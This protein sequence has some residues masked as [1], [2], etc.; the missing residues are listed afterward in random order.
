MGRR[1]R[2]RGPPPARAEGRGGLRGFQPAETGSR[3]AGRIFSCSCAEPVRGHGTAGPGRGPV[4]GGRAGLVADAALG[5]WRI[6]AA[7]VPA[8]VVSGNFVRLPHLLPGGSPIFWAAGREEAREPQRRLLPTPSARL[9]GFRRP[10]PTPG[11]SPGAAEAPA[12]GHGLWVLC[13]RP[14]LLPSPPPVTPPLSGPAM[15]SPPPHP[16]VA[17]HPLR[18]ASAAFSIFQRYLVH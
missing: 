4:R 12:P 15:V 9:A 6:R 8:T 16:A 5:S 2:A 1:E 18:A 10:H 14:R 11:C 17:I 3:A 7:G 13:E